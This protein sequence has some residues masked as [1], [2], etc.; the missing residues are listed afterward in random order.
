MLDVHEPA[1]NNRRDNWTE[2]RRS[3]VQ[4][5]LAGEIGLLH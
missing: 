4:S 2:C 3:K 1:L 5:P